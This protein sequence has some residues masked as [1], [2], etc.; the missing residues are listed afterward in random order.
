GLAPALGLLIPVTYLHIP[1]I[2][3]IPVCLL[4]GTLIGAFN[5]TLVVRFGL[6][7]FIVTLGMLIVLRGLQVGFTGGKSLF[8]APPEFFYLGSASWFGLPASIWL[9]AIAYAIGMVVLGFFRHGRALY[10][11]GGNSDAARAAG[12]RTDRVIFGVFVVA[13]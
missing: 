6:S 8:T 9:C 7:A 13:G 10:A 3:A 5:G 2:W 1:G 12:I 4:V 11:V